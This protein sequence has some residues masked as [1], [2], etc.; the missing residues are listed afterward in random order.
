M[1]SFMDDSAAT[2]LLVGGRVFVVAFLLFMEG[3]G[4]SLSSP[5]SVIVSEVE[6]D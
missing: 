4:T 3:V 2:G 6:D 5:P 1:L